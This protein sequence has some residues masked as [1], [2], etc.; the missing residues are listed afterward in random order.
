MRIRALRQFSHYHHGTFDP[1]ETRLVSDEAGAALVGM[2][3]AEEVGNAGTPVA[4][5]DTAETTP[6]ANKPRRARGRVAP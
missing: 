4:P 3:L 2:G 5:T 6:P 1:G